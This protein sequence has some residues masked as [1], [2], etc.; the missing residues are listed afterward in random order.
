MLQA[1]EGSRYLGSPLFSFWLVD[2][3][4]I[5]SRSLAL[6]PGLF[7]YVKGLC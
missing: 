3:D 2:E 1:T 4:F 5:S 7:S 6:I